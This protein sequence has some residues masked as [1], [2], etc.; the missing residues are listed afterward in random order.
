M[1]SCI[2]YYYRNREQRLEYQRIYRILNKYNLLPKYES[3]Q[4]LV[5]KEMYKPVYKKSNEVRVLNFD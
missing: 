2:N 5:K 3:Q 1:P 4:E